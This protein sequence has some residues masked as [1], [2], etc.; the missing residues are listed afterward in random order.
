MCYNLFGGN[1]MKILIITIIFLLV[2][3]PIFAQEINQ[4]VIQDINKTTVN[5]AKVVIISSV[6]LI[7]IF[8]VSLFIYGLTLDRVE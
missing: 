8:V 1:K 3:T 2:F 4:D 7:G 6:C 5:I